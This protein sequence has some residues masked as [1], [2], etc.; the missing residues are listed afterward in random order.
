MPTWAKALATILALA[1]ADVY[2]SHRDREVETWS[3]TCHATLEHLTAAIETN[4]LEAESCNGRLLACLE[5]EDAER[6]SSPGWI[7]GH[8]LELARSE[9]GAGEVPPETGGP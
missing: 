4:H 6:Q 5:G 8:V 7:H 9:E 3:S 2:K 1:A